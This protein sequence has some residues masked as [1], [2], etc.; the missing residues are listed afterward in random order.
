MHDDG[1]FSDKQ[2][3][4]AFSCPKAVLSACIRTRTPLKHFTFSGCTF[5]KDPG[6]Y[7]I[8][9]DRMDLIVQLLIFPSPIFG[10]ITDFCFRIMKELT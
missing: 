10:Y 4:A 1:R 8:L 2:G 6:Q 9:P 3:G 5:A 7:F